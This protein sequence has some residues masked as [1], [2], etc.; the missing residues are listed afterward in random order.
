MK[1]TLGVLTAV[2]FLFI[3]CSSLGTGKSQEGGMKPSV[4][5]AGPVKLDKKAKTMIKGKGF[6]PGQE[7]YVVFTDKNGIESDIGYA[8]KPAP[9]ADDKG[10][11]ST[12]WNC[13]HFVAKKLVK[14]GEFKLTVTDMDY[15]PLARTM[16]RFQK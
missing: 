9:K 6:K 11:W 15:N 3:G 10:N 4:E 1:K 13:A 8:L 14:E 5:M 12:S 16:V 2:I 7:V